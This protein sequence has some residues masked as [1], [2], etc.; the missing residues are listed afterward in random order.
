MDSA[1]E[2]N[3]ALRMPSR[4]VANIVGVRGDRI[5]SCQLPGVVQSAKHAE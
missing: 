3:V 1:D 2:V 4:E 5:S